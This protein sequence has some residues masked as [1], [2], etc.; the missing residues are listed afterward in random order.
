MIF[1]PPNY[2]VGMYER[3]KSFPSHYYQSTYNSTYDHTVSEKIILFLCVPAHGC[4]LCEQFDL[5]HNALHGRARKAV[6]VSTSY[7]YYEGAVTP[8]Y[9]CTGYRFN[10]GRMGIFCK[11]WNIICNLDLN[12]RWGSPR[13]L[14]RYIELLPHDLR[15]LV[16]Y[17][18]KHLGQSGVVLRQ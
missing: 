14:H 10:R 8:I 3:L 16:P 6:D 4:W 17:R 2:T 13:G 12:R 9:D 18:W 1:L 15:S 7:E 5:R 11:V